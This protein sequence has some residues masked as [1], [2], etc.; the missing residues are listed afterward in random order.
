MALYDNPPHRVTSS[1]VAHTKD[2]DGGDVAAFTTVQAGIP[3]I[4]NTASGSE[5]AL[6]AAQ[7]LVVTHMIAVLSSALTTPLARGMKL[8]DGDTGANY[9]VEDLRAGR[10]MGNIPAFTYAGVRQIL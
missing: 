2:T 4:I 7:N 3:C 6:F 5:Q 10:E 8:T 9:H 1:S